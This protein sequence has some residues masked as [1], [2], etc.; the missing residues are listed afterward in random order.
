MSKGISNFQ[1]ELAL[2]DNDITKKFVVVFP[3]N[4][5]NK[6]IDFKSMKSENTSKYPFLI[7][8]TESLDKNG[9]HWWS[10]LDI[11]PMTD[12]FFFDSFGIGDLKNFI[13]QDDKM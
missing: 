10:V 8:N 5:M 3:A 9:T 1:I 7:A 2:N 6:F 4:H 12:L 11:E 13:I